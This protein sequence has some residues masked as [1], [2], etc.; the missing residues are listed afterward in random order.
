[1]VYIGNNGKAASV[2]SIKVGD[3]NGKA[4]NVIGGWVGDENGKARRIWSLD[5]PMWKFTCQTGVNLHVSGS[6]LAIDYGDG[7]GENIGTQTSLYHTSHI[8]A[9][10]EPHQITLYGVLSDVRFWIN[11]EGPAKDYLLSVDTPFPKNRIRDIAAAFRDCTSLTYIPVGLF[12]NCP[13]VTD[14][15]VAFYGCTSLAAIPAGLFD[16]CPNVTNF[17][18]TFYGCTAITSDVPELWD[19]SKWPNVRYHESCFFN[20]TN[21]ANYADIPEGWK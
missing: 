16:N 11:D 13:N 15:G 3:E 9:D 14:F 10:A 4:A 20:C 5:R 7:S 12:D 18:N 19:T 1:M 8:Y 21:A 2:S 6:G 17:N